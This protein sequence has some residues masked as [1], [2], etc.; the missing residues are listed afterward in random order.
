M[1]T[2]WLPDEI[3]PM[4]V[5]A[6]TQEVKVRTWYPAS[7]HETGSKTM[8]GKDRY[9]GGADG[10]LGITTPSMDDPPPCMIAVAARASS[11]MCALLSRVIDEPVDVTSLNT[12]ALLLRC[13]EPAA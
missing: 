1:R 2:T 12:E 3:E 6:S 7:I 11:K 5:L 9:S 4:K 10:E 13:T 8:S